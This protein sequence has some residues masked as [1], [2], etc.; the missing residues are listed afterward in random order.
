MRCPILMA[1]IHTIMMSWCMFPKEKGV[2][3]TE[4]I[5]G[6]SIIFQL[7]MEAEISGEL[8]QKQV[9]GQFGD[10]GI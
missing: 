8:K 5:L 3:N 4:Y 10:G 9:N 7:T 6:N 2:A 1:K